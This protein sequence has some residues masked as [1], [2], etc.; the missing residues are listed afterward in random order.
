[1]PDLTALRFIDCNVFIGRPTVRSHWQPASASDLIWEMDR[2]GIAQSL[3][4][5]IAQHDAFPLL[6]ND[7]LDEAIGPHRDRLIP[8]WSILP[9]QSGELGDLDAWFDRAGDA[10]VRALRAWPNRGRYLLRREAVGDIVERMV[11]RRMPLICSVT[12]ESDW[13]D[14]YDLLGYF[15]ELRVILSYTSCWSADRYF[16]PLVEAYAHVYVEISA[17]FPPGGIEAFA[18]KYGSERMLYGSAFPTAYHG[19]MMLMV[20]HADIAFEDKEAIAA[21]NIERLMKEVAL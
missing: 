9:S 17:Y 14:V 19:A 8:C 13:R 5:H 20:A 11:D 18:G 7:L 1:M 16:R 6:G 10:G 15:P 4:W 2:A 3:V 21:G 12:S